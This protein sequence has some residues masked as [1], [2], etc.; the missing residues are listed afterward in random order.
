MNR[1]RLLKTLSLSTPAILWAHQ[2][3]LGADL[4]DAAKAGHAF[5]ADVVILGGG[6]G[7]V[8]AALAAARKGLRV[9]LTEESDW[10]GGQITA[11][12]V[13][14]DEHPHIESYGVNASYRELR[15]RIR[16]YYRNHYPL[17]E[18][19]KKKGWLNPGQGSVSRLCHEPRVGLAALYE[20]L[21]PHLSTGRITLLLQ[22]RLRSA[23][24]TGDKIN[25]VTVE[26]LRSGTMRTLEAPFFIDATE[27]GDLLPASGTEWITGAEAQSDTGELHAA[28]TADLDNLQAA[29]WCFPIEYVDGANFVG[30]APKDYDFWRSYVPD[31]TPA[32]PGPLFS[33]TYSH[34]RTLEPR[35]LGF[36]PKNEPAGSSW[37]T[38]R[39]IAWKE[40]FLPG[41]YAGSISLVNWPQNDYLLGHFLGDEAATQ[42]HLEGAKQLSLSL[43]HWLQT[44]APRPDGG[45]GW[46][47]LRLRPELTGTV[48]GLA[49]APYIRESRRILAEFT[50]LEKHVGE[51]A[52]RI[53]LGK[54][55]GAITAAE[56]EDSVGVGAYHIDLHPSTAGDNYIDVPSLPFQIPLGV[57]IPQRV[58]NLLAA[59]KNIGTTH[60]TNGCYRLH[61]VEW[62]IGE[63]AGSLI[64]YCHLQ[65]KQTKQVRNTPDLLADFQTTLT[66]Q[67]VELEWKK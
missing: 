8:S 57:L 67:G 25:A 49:M 43:F 15:N 27:L 39:R 38:Y 62:N 56:F 10:V 17:T 22:H 24:V 58:E 12:V 3:A 53:E 41:T 26:D 35:T 30:D 42:R 2:R 14:P 29:T 60:I 65:K 9:L 5:R 51:E 54:A 66:K 4:G 36:D 40:N 47:E 31:L 23:E 46:P 55:E 48:D 45:T 59:N 44:E 33:F 32:W 61:P 28:E 1:R 13:P 18:D 20:M 63:A 7:G 11:Q 21:N 50:I 19:A 34:P 52:R 6:L 16:D 37:W 64:A